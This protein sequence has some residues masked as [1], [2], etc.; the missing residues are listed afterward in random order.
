M[1]YSRRSVYTEEVNIANTITIARII[2]VSLIFWITPYSTN[3]TL[4]LTA[5]IYALVASTDYIDGWIARKLNIVSDLGKILDP[6]ADKILVLVFLPL[7]QMQAITAFPVFVILTREFAIM[8]LRVMAAKQGSIIQASFSGKIKTAITLPVC[9]ILFARVP[10][11]LVHIPLVLKPIEWLREWIFHWPNWMFNLL[12]WAAVAVTIWSFLD[13]FFRFIWQL[14]LKKANGNEVEA[15]RLLRMVIPNTVTMLNLSFGLL[16][17]LWAALGNIQNAVLMILCCIVFD[18]TD[19]FLARK[20]DAFSKFGASLDSKADFV[21]F[22]IA[23]GTLIYSY[24]AQSALPF[25][26]IIGGVLGL[27]FFVSV[28]YR[29]RR[30][31]KT[32]HSDYFEGVPSPTGAAI[33]AVFSITP[34]ITNPVIFGLIAILISGLMASKIAYPHISGTKHSFLKYL[35]KPLQIITIVCIMSLAGLNLP[36]FLHIFELFLGFGIVYLLSPIITPKHSDHA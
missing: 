12:I 29:L 8:A 6:L 32:G 3:L 23:P 10:V 19:G 36:R 25:G 17:V 15:K 34:Y 24:M 9:G 5:I 26:P 31:N 14:Y 11:E 33:T 18:A 16:G 21:A 28:A 22:G 13:Y 2:G 7:L 35:V 20:L 30:F 1:A 4:I 27:T